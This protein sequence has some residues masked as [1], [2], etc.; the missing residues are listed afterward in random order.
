MGEFLHHYTELMSDPAHMAVELTFILLIDG[1]VLGLILPFV[2]TSINKRVEAE[3]KGLDQE[4][5]DAH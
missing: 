4:H 3:H 1:L 5:R 2:R